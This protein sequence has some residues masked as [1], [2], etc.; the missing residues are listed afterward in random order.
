MK[1]SK[2]LEPSAW[3][4]VYGIGSTGRSVALSDGGGFDG[5]EAMMAVPIGG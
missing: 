5:D 2:Y 4:C 3:Q 1:I